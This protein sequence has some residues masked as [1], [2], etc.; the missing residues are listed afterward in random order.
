MS[1]GRRVAVS[2]DV[3]RRCVEHVAREG[4]ATF[5][6]RRGWRAEL[7]TIVR[8]AGGAHSGACR[9]TLAVESADSQRAAIEE[10]LDR[11]RSMLNDKL[12]TRTVNHVC[13]PWGVSGSQTAA[14]LGRLGFRTA[15]ANRLRGVHAV[16]RGDDPFWLK[17]LPNRHIYRLPGRGRRTFV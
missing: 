4:G 17:R 9:P 15:F 13:L 11:G 14:A 3:H 5:F 16:R 7:D 12:G 1:D 6:D 2:D 8:G 10:E